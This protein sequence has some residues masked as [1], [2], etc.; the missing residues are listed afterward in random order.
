VSLEG[1]QAGVDHSSQILA[2]CLADDGP[3]P[4]QVAA[5]RE[6]AVRLADT[7]A[8]LP[9]HYQRVLLLRLFEG[10]SADEVAERMSTT[11]GAVRMM[12]M[13]ALEALR[14]LMRGDIPPG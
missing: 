4:S 5:E 10:L 14:E 1:F 8:R 12:Q 11:A 6:S 13:R 2:R 3:T 9:E 7:L